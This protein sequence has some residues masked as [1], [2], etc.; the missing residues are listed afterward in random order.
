MGYGHALPD[1][2]QQSIDLELQAEISSWATLHTFSN[3]LTI[4]AT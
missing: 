2:K 1:L 3:Q 4:L